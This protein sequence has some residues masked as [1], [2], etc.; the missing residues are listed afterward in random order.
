MNATYSEMA[1][2][3]GVAIIPARCLQAPR[4][5]QGRVGGS[6]G[7]ALDHRPAAKRALHQ[8]GRGQ[9]RDPPPHAMGERTAF[10]EA[11]RVEKDPCSKRSTDRRL[12]PLA[13]T[14]YEFATWRKAKLGID[15]H[16]EVRADRHY[17]S[18]ALPPRRRSG[19]GPAVGS[20][21]RGLLSP[22]PRGVPRA[23]LPARLHHRPCPHARIPPSAR[24]VDTVASHLMGSPDRAH[25]LPS[26]P[27]PSWRRDRIPNRAFAVAW[28][29]SDFRTATAPI[30]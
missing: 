9:R 2:H 27:K 12:R 14:R 3:Y 8:P 28:A 1:A 24:Q 5:G 23:Q 17:Y 20:Y 19:R 15:Y 29:S 6:G 26:S 13:A 11:R 18:V 4:Q 25:R 7:R 10:Q 30:A 22:P 21:G 16:V